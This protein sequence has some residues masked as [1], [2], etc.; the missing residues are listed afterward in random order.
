MGKSFIDTI[1]IIAGK[2]PLMSR[3]LIAVILMF[4]VA[5]YILAQD[6]TE[7]NICGNCHQPIIAKALTSR[8]MHSVVME[9]CPLC[10]ISQGSQGSQGNPTKKGEVEVLTSWYKTRYVIPLKNLSKERYQVAVVVKNEN[11]AATKMTF[12]LSLADIKSI[13]IDNMPPDIGEVTVKAI[14]DTAFINVINADISWKTDKPSFS[15]IEYG[16][17]EKYGHSVSRR[18]MFLQEH[19]LTIAGLTKNKTYH[20][21]ILGQDIFRNRTL[22]KDFI[23]E[24]T[25]LLKDKTVEKVKMDDPQVRSITFYRTGDMKELFTDVTTDVPSQIN[26]NFNEDISL[27][28][29]TKHGNGLLSPRN[30]RIDVCTT[31][32][33]H[34]QGASHP[35]GGRVRSPKFKQPKNLPLIEGDVM[36]CTTCHEPHGG[37]LKYMLRKDF[38]TA[39]CIECHRDNDY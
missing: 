36:T 28:D 7:A 39:V 20:F 9:R 24:T 30:V 17:T 18:D 19:T 34:P 26:I 3:F 27:S 25:V 13:Q 35:V 6:R 23:L 4:P 12:P 31:V 10:H 5:I 11:G 33:C 2:F 16:E 14:R 32:S 21:R 15:V 29:T 22:S 37:N 38:M 8:Y 1:I